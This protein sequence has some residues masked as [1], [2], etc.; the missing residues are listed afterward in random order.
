M[1][2]YSEFCLRLLS[3]IRKYISNAGCVWYRLLPSLKPGK[4]QKGGEDTVARG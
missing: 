3:F 1:E 2:W 4:H